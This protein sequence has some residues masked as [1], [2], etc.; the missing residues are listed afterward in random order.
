VGKEYGAIF[1]LTDAGLFQEEDDVNGDG[2]C[3][4][5]DGFPVFALGG[6]L[7]PGNIQYLDTNG[8]G[9]VDLA[10]EQRIGYPAI[11][12]I[13][14][15]LGLDIS[16]KGFDL[17]LL[18][19]GAGHSNMYIEGTYIRAFAE[20]R[21]YPTFLLNDSWTPENTDARFPA[22]SPTGVNANDALPN[23]TFYMLNA[24][25]LRLKY[26]ELGYTLPAQWANYLRLGS[27]RLYASG[28][29]LFTLSE[30]V[31]YYL[32]PEASQVGQRGWY[33][34]M[35]RTFTFGINIGF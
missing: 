2:V 31:D 26:A 29:N 5:L 33:H 3:D 22:L 9:V 7:G 18:F 6:T 13:I 15:S 34:P 23:T 20:T 32:D 30:M 21:N 14:Y 24:A 27:V 4:T 35:Q 25:Y 28:I 1:G 12:E 19:Q 10:D 16:W 8:D 11:P 17:N